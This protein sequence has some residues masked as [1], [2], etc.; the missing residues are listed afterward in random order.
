MNFHVSAGC[1]GKFRLEYMS[2]QKEGIQWEARS[3][4]VNFEDSVSSQ[5][6][7][8]SIQGNGHRNANTGAYSGCGKAN[9]LANA[10]DDDG[11]EPVI[12]QV[13]IHEVPQPTPEAHDC[14]AMDVDVDARDNPVG[15]LAMGLEQLS[16]GG[17]KKQHDCA[18]VGSQPKADPVA[19]QEAV[20]QDV[21]ILQLPCS[22]PMEDGQRKEDEEAE[23]CVHHREEAP[24][25]GRIH[26]HPL[27]LHGEKT[28]RAASSQVTMAQG[29]GTANHL[30]S[31]HDF[32]SLPRCSL[33]NG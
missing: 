6:V 27:H 20:W 30:H 32:V 26:R 24:Q 23:T 11:V 5:Q 18:E 22:P 4:Y 28:G 8:I 15:D 2:K 25:V 12:C 3:A 14:P 17:L 33:I 31:G 9:A 19:V 10:V 29:R 7:W 1:K 21:D 13:D 16:Q